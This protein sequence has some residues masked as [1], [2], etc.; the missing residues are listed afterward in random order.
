MTNKSKT[1]YTGVTNDLLRR[2]FEHKRKLVDGFTKRYNI[3]RLIW[4]E[5]FDNPEE[6]IACEKRL[7]GWLRRKKI[8]L[9]EG[10]NPQWEDLS[11]DWFGDSSALPQNDTRG[12]FN[13]E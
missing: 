1:L 3:T 11:E 2:V 4:Y 10:K 7:K 12:M 5:Q 8:F 13:N 6:A 9:I